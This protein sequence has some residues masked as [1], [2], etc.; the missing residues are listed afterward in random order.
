MARIAGF[1]LWELLWTLIIGGTLLG[2]GVPSF[3]TFLLDSRR[4]ADINALVLAIQLARSEAAKRG[5]P[6]VVCKSVDRL[7]CGGDEIRFDA[8]WMVFANAD[9]I[10]PPHRSPS[11]P[12]LYA[13][14]PEL[15]GTITA[16][17]PLFE[18]RPYLRRSTNG[19]V[20][21]CDR[22]GGRAARAVIVSY[23]GRPRVDSV[24]PGGE[25]LPCAG[26]P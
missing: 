15:K 26:L 4:T 2:L 7:R 23:T 17:R 3:Q 22:R 5:Q 8:G 14:V 9:D 19:T 25:A 12:L 20:T 21:F 18:F 24:G 13:H 10:R 6:V 16:N 1:T 11:E